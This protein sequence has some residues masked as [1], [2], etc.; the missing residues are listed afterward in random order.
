MPLNQ[1]APNPG[2]PRAARTVVI[3]VGSVCAAATLSCM[4]SL[5]PVAP[6]SDYQKGFTAE[7]PLHNA[8]L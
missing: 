5:S 2:F 4:V 1:I 6:L 3:I 7:E 8:A